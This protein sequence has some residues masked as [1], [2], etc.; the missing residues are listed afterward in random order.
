MSFIAAASIFGSIASAAVLA[1]SS[2]AS[3]APTTCPA[4]SGVVCG[5]I[6]SESSPTLQAGVLSQA[7]GNWDINFIG[8]APIKAGDF[9]QIQVLDNKGDDT[10]G[11]APT[12]PTVSAPA[13]TVT[14]AVQLDDAA[15]YGVGP[16][17]ACVPD[18]SPQS[19]ASPDCN[20]LDITFTNNFTTAPA[21][22]SLTVSNIFYDLSSKANNGPITVGEYDVFA[23]NTA[24]AGHANFIPAGTS[25]PA[26]A[27]IFQTARN[28]SFTATD[29]PVIGLGQP[30]QP[31]GDWALTVGNGKQAPSGWSVGEQWVISIATQDGTNCVFPDDNI[32]FNGSPADISVQVYANAPQVTAVPT[33]AT[34]TFAESTLCSKAGIAD[35]LVLTTTNS[36]QIPGYY[37]AMPIT[38]IIDNVTYN[39]GTNAGFFNTATGHSPVGPIY[40]GISIPG[41]NLPLSKVATPYGPSNAYVSNVTMTANTPPVDLVPHTINGSISPI[42]ISELGTPGVFPAIFNNWYVCVTLDQESGSTWYSQSTTTA[43]VTSG[44]ATVAN[45]GAVSG[46]GTRTLYFQVATQSVTDNSTYLLNPLSV[47][48]DSHYTGPVTAYVSAGPD[49]QVNGNS[50]QCGSPSYVSGTN[51]TSNVTTLGGG[52]E[53]Q[54]TEPIQVFAVVQTNRIYGSVADAT[55]AATF[56]NQFQ[57]TGP[58]TTCPPN[59]NAVLA[60]DLDPS[61]ALTGNFLA[62][63]LQTGILLSGP[64][65]P[66]SYLLNALRIEGVRTVYRLGGPAVWSS[67]FDS[68]LESQQVYACGGATPLTNADGSPQTIKVVDIYGPDADGTAMAVSEFF[69]QAGVGAANFG[70]AYCGT[71]PYCTGTDLYNVTSGMSSPS[72]PTQTVTSGTHPF[73]SC[74]QRLYLSGNCWPTAIVVTDQT[75][76][77]AA[78]ASPMAY[79]GHFPVISTPSDTLSNEAMSA[80]QDLGIQ[81]VI[82]MGGP[83][84]ISDGVVSTIQGL[85][86]SVL[87]IAG[88]TYVGTSVQ[89]ASFELSNWQVVVGLQYNPAG[90][91]WGSTK[92]NGVVAARGDFWTDAIA[93]GVVEG[94]GN[95]LSQ[96]FS[97]TPCGTGM[98][99]DST[100]PPGNNFFPSGSVAAGTDFGYTN[101][102]TAVTGVPTC[103]EALVLTQDTNTVGPELDSFLMA[104]GARWRYWHIGSFNPIFAITVLGGPAALANSTVSDMLTDIATQPVNP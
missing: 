78:S 64:D 39:V 86:M 27:T 72:Q 81:Q 22:L 37:P 73:Y 98:T 94:S 11:F 104:N 62:G 53:N 75:W 71:T 32:G 42:S 23:E 10:V 17:P 28:F 20:V 31:A 100:F 97:G 6:V 55:A 8:N 56:E 57:G 82:V 35:E 66:G 95:G 29:T 12:V 4:P 3:A 61:D 15:S 45:G 74:P 44:D 84:A 93:G 85:G 48:T 87:R 7:A 38:I 54:L 47:V 101:G 92:S 5:Q 19:P 76:Q 99:P 88:D 63:E 24:P 58:A 26:N 2:S 96:I 65:T 36:G 77:D 43:S 9:I 50:T 59:E 1:G 68:D 60:T 41:G 21:G 18:D 80:L 70:G 13:G 83:D 67:T 16:G 89:A 34:P 52:F 90:L 25:G 40:A 102:T 14:T 51:N 103:P 46:F 49:I 79:W 33:F 91:N 30:D 69:G